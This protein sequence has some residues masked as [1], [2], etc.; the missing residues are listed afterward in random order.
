RLRG[1][2]RR[3]SAGPV[4]SMTC[5]WYRRSGTHGY[6]VPRRQ[7]AGTEN[8]RIRADLVEGDGGQSGAGEQVGPLLRDGEG[9]DRVVDR[10]G[11]PD[12]HP[13]TRERVHIERVEGCGLL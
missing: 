9:V 1:C 2:R 6:T 3:R 11:D 8:C 7:A 13:H 12:R 10:G 4:T 5:P